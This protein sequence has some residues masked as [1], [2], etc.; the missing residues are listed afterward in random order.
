MCQQ[1]STWMSTSIKFELLQFLVQWSWGDNKKFVKSP[2]LTLVVKCVK[3]HFKHS[4]LSRAFIYNCS[5]GQGSTQPLYVFLQVYDNKMVVL[6]PDFNLG[7]PA[8]RLENKHKGEIG[9]EEK[10]DW[11]ID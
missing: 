10:R 7:K 2:H 8:Y 4:L 11:L 5:F 3:S 6:K 1:I 9:R